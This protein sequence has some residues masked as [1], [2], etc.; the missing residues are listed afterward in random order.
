MAKQLVNKGAKKRKKEMMLHLNP[1]V[2]FLSGTGKKVKLT[3][4]KS[5][6]RAYVY[7]A[8][9]DEWEDM[10]LGSLRANVLQEYIRKNF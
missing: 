7:N 1:D 5:E 3:F 6:Y 8:R 9:Y 4:Q 10:K 2:E